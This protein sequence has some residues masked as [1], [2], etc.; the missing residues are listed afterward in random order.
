MAHR[1]VVSNLSHRFAI[2]PWDSML[3]NVES[4][5]RMREIGAA[6]KKNVHS[7]LESLGLYPMTQRLGMS[8]DEFNDLVARARQEA[9]DHR[10][11]PYLPLL[12]LPI[13][14]QGRH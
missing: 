2:E 10:L 12:V 9:E 8:D 4:D 13:R 14:H 7:L 11:K 5:P 3:T 1:Y 6:N